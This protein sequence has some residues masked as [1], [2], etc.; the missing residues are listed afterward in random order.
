MANHDVCLTSIYGVIKNLGC[1]SPV[2]L[3]HSPLPHSLTPSL[4]HFLTPSLPPPSLSQATNFE[5][6]LSGAV[7][8]LKEADGPVEQHPLVAAFKGAIRVGS[9][10][11]RGRERVRK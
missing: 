8:G 2:P 5:A 7:A 11:G 1:P 4:P 3:P 10:R 6:Q 9:G